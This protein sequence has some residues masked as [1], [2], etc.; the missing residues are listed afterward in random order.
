MVEAAG[1]GVPGYAVERGGGEC[2]EAA[3]GVK[4]P[5]LLA[6]VEDLFRDEVVGVVSVR[7]PARQG[8]DTAERVVFVAGV[9][10]PVGGVLA[11]VG[12]SINGAGRS[13]RSV[14]VRAV[15]IAAVAVGAGVVGV[16]ARGAAVDRVGGGGEAAEAVVVERPG[17]AGVRL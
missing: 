12:L 1:R 14:C 4:R 6:G 17:S 7:E 8:C 5:T 9:G 10:D 11:V 16:H 3:V 2:P 13:A 15:G